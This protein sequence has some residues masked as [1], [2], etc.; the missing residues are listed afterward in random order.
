MNGCAGLTIFKDVGAYL[1]SSACAN[2]S[3]QIAWHWSFD[4]K[5]HTKYR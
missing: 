3:W 4:I 2:K 5:G 1:L